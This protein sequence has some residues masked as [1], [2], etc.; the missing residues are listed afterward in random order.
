M[1]N[2]LSDTKKKVIEEYGVWGVKRQYGKES[3]GIIRST[4]LISPNGEIK[5]AWKDVQV[6]EHVEKVLAKLKDV[7]E[8]Y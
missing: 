8:S 4:V 3:Y 2:L 7:Q 1:V 5:Y 6:R